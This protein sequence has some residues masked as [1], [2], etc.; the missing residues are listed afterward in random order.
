MDGIRPL[1]LVCVL[2][3]FHIIGMRAGNEADVKEEQ[4]EEPEECPYI[5]PLAEMERWND[6]DF[7]TCRIRKMRPTEEEADD[8]ERYM[9]GE[10]YYSY[11]IFASDRIGARRKLND[12]ETHEK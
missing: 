10:Q 12:T 8:Y 6:Y 3:A 9:Y 5:D 1:R 11:N 2:I 4:R 7:S